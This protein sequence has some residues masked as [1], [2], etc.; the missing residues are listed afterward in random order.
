MAI[1]S[2]YT[3]KGFAPDIDTSSKVPEIVMNMVNQKEAR[4]ARDKQILA[5][6]V[7]L[8]I[9]ELE[10]VS[11]DK[12]LSYLQQF[13][14]KATPY[15]MKEELSTQDI[16][17]LGKLR[18]KTEMEINK[19]KLEQDK[20]NGLVKMIYT[21]PDKVH[22]QDAYEAFEEY[23]NTGTITKR[24]APK[25]EIEDVMKVSTAIDK[26]LFEQYDPETGKT[27]KTNVTEEVLS[28]RDLLLRNS[29]EIQ[30][31][32]R[33]TNQ[34]V[35]NVMNTL[36]PRVT[37]KPVRTDYSSGRSGGKTSSTETITD[38][39]LHLMKQ[40]INYMTEKNPYG[41]KEYDKYQEFQ[42]NTLMYPLSGEAKI[43]I[44]TDEL[45]DTKSGNI[46]KDK[47]K[48]IEGDI[49]GLVY[50]PVDENYKLI[51]K[52]TDTRE[53]K[54]KLGKPTTETYD[55]FSL[56]DNDFSLK[57][58]IDELDENKKL[59]TAIRIRSGQE[60]YDI[61]FT[62]TAKQTLLNNKKFK[63]AYPKLYQDI[64]NLQTG[65]VPISYIKN[66]NIDGDV[67]KVDGSKKIVI[68]PNSPL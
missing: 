68:K 57:A 18:S 56:Y 34:T 40:S 62:E 3:G 23:K 66:L 26:S 16:F 39:K 31:Y 50:L 64:Q 8:D 27:V 33:Q 37:T 15:Y 53:G 20:F 51:K 63:E 55:I 30:E 22:L 36:L 52:K 24:I 35:D 12:Q 14:E 46:L 67:K 1:Q 6:L 43:T 58:N 29:N 17:E 28:S 41:D 45:I 59:G 44:N 25:I 2:I 48:A 13:E 4:K 32:A 60:T 10:G 65:L 5:S 61:P 47:G 19:L 49:V 42:I 11:A 54:P 9:A 7:D 38:T 21:N